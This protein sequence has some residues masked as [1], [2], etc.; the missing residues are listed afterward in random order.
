MEAEERQEERETPPMSAIS[1]LQ[2][3]THH[4]LLFLPPHYELSEV[5]SFNLAKNH[6]ADG[7]FSTST[8]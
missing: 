3:S 6:I 4:L 2:Y 8:V 1:S 7:F 5:L